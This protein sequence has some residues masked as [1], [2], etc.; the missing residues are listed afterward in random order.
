MYGPRGKHVFFGFDLFYQNYSLY[1]DN[2]ANGAK[3]GNG[4]TGTMDRLD[5]SYAFF[6]PK[7]CY[8]LGRKENVKVFITCGVGYNIS[9]YDSLRKWDYGYST[10]TGGAGS[11]QYDS[12]IGKTKNINKMLFRVGLG[13]TEYAA[14]GYHWRFTFTEDFGFLNKQLTTTGTVTDQSRTQYSTNG[15]QPGYISL[16]I[17]ISHISWKKDNY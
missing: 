2:E 6:A 11:G 1:A 13:L 3:G 4:Y 7:F 16:Q 14:I 15:L 10:I 8:G 9:G 12:V 17:G 5:A